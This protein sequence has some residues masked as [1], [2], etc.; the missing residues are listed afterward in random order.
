MESKELDFVSKLQVQVI[1]V[2]V[3]IANDG[4]SIDNR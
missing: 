3:A 2:R 1:R 4:F